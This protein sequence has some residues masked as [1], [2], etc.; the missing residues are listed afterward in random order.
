VGFVIDLGEE[1]DVGLVQAYYFQIA[2][3]ST[4]KCYVSPDNSDYTLTDTK[5]LN[6]GSFLEIYQFKVNQQARYIKLVQDDGANQN[7]N[8]SFSYKGVEIYQENIN[9]QYEIVRENGNISY[10]DTYNANNLVNIVTGLKKDTE[11]YKDQ[12]EQSAK[13][14]AD[15][16]SKINGKAGTVGGYPILENIGGEPKIP[17]VYINQ[18]DIKEYIQITSESELDTIDAQ[19]GDVALLTETVNGELTVTKS[20]I[21]LSVTGTTRTWAVYGTSYATNSGNAQ[22]AQTATNALQINGNIINK[23]SQADYNALTDKTGIYFVIIGE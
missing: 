22:T 3:E 1:K 23:I 4:V 13:D 12:A 16:L 11:D 6:P 15:S 8:G 21:L 18:V 9:G 14:S 2:W 17:A 7:T 5:V 20:W 19:V 10:I